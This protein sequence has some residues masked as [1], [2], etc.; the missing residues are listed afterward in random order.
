MATYT[1]RPQAAVGENGQLTNEGSGQLF[2]ISDTT[3]TTPLVARDVSGANKTVIA[4]S[5]IGQTETFLIDDHPEL[6][7][8]SGATVVH[9]FSISGLL[10]RAEAAAATSATAV[11]A[12]NVSRAAA[13][14]AQAAVTALIAKAVLTVNGAFPDVNGN[15][16]IA[17]GGSGGG[18]ILTV[19]GRGPDGTGNVA[20]LV[21]S[22]IG[23]ATTAHTHTFASKNGFTGVTGTASATTFLRGDGTWSV[24]PTGGGGGG[25]VNS[26]NTISPVSGNVTLNK[27]H[28]ELGEVDNVSDA[29]KP[30]SVAT[31]QQLELKAAVNAVVALTGNQTIAG[32]KTFSSAPVVPANSF[33]IDKVNGLQTALNAKVDG[34]NGVTGL[35]KGSQTAYDALSSKP[36]GVVYLITGA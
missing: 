35:W 25:S 12:A 1:Y 19:M 33:A 16:Q 5:G 15:V 13:E 23:A 36:A 34:L 9:L 2:A 4:L 29:N 27:S 31:Q 28:L 7:W 32:V 14:A 30:V 10:E 20:T 6:W 3:F 18:G 17:T 24:P 22:D 21:P 11:T 8:K 26:V